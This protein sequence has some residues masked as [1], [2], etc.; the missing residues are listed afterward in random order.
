MSLKICTV[1]VRSLIKRIGCLNQLLF[2]NNVDVLCVQ[3]WIQRIGFSLNQLKRFTVLIDPV[4]QP[5]QRFK[6][7]C[8]GKFQHEWMNLVRT[9]C[10]LQILN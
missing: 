8:R 4:E 3:E 6:D 10:L 7:T 1:N 9:R 5:H 2:D